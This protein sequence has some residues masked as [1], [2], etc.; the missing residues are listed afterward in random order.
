MERNYIVDYTI[1]KLNSSESIEMCHITYND[2]GDC[3]LRLYHDKNKY[4]LAELTKFY[5]FSTDINR[6]FVN[7]KKDYIDDYVICSRYKPDYKIGTFY[8]LKACSF[9]E[10]K[11]KICVGVDFEFMVA[12]ADEPLSLGILQ[13]FKPKELFSKRVSVCEEETVDGW[14]N[15]VDIPESIAEP[16]VIKTNYFGKYYVGHYNEGWW[17]L[18]G[19]VYKPASEVLDTLNLISENENCGEVKFLE[20]KYINT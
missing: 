19:D 16:L 11:D 2:E 9:E 8:A 10:L 17:V 1:K 7:N 13:A 12:N 20:W 5:K 15:F 6:G 18:W 14:H 3:D 4:T